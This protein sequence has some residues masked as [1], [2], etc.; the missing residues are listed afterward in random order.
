M[1]RNGLIRM[2]AQDVRMWV[3]TGE[4]PTRVVAQM[5]RLLA[6]D[7]KLVTPTGARFGLSLGTV[8]ARRPV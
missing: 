2:T 7:R 3:A 5:V 4:L 6:R 8:A 1:R